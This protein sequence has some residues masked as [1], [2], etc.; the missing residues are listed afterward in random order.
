MNEIDVGKTRPQKTNERWR[1]L[2][3]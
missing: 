1:C 2:A 3:S